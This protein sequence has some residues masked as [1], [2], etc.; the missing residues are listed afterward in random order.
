VSTIEPDWPALL[1]F[2]T[3]WA[4]CCAVFFLLAD[5]VPVRGRPAMDATRLEFGLIVANVTLLLGLVASSLVYAIIQLKITS[6]IVALGLIFLFSP[7]LLRFIPPLVGNPRSSSIILMMVQVSLLCLIWTG[8]IAT[9][10]G[11]G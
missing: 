6:T 9:L 3:L 11:E 2:S 10:V 5:L 7:A 1:G 4:I 8:K